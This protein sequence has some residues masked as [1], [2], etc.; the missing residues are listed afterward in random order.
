MQRCLGFTVTLN[1]MREK[2]RI[3]LITDGNEIAAWAYAMI[4]KINAIAGSEMVVLITVAPQYPKKQNLFKRFIKTYPTLL[5][6]LF[7]KLEAFLFKMTHN[8]FALRDINDIVTLPTLTASIDTDSNTLFVNA[9]DIEKLQLWNLDVLV[10]LSEHLP[11]KELLKLAKYGCWTLHHGDI[12][13]VKGGP[14]SFW[15]VIEHHP[16]TGVSLLMHTHQ[17]PY[18][19]LLHQSY[20]QT[21]GL[22]ITR[23]RNNCAWKALSFIPQKINELINGGHDAFLTRIAELNKHP[24]FYSGKVYNTPGNGK[25]LMLGTKYLWEYACQKVESLFYFEQWV[26]LY[27]IN[28]HEMLTPCLPR[29]KKM[30]PPKDKFWADPFVVYRNNKYYI[31]I[32]E[33]V[34]ATNKGHIAVIEMDENGNYSAPEI[35]LEKGYHLSYPFLLEDNGDLYMIPESFE[36]KTISL[37]KCIEFPHKWAFETHLIDNITAVD[38]TITIKDGKYWLFA[39]VVS[40]KG[41]ST[42]DEL[43]IF[44]A[45]KLV[46]NQW[47]PHAQNPVISDVK[48]ARPAGNFFMHNNQLY[49]PSQNCSNR[50][51]YGMQINH[52][53][54]LNESNYS[55]VVVDSINPF[56]HNRL[57]AT[58]TINHANKLTLIDALLKRRK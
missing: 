6:S 17:H 39:N 40:H 30:L 35:V 7:I 58:H 37:Y 26:L 51:G 41:A 38:A 10:G 31:F 2:L 33:L 15:E 4:K 43:C 21:D 36:N 11:H 8:A 19:T 53:I 18:P 3:G 42:H 49:R 47:T 29:Y 25:M 56:W 34:Y 9:A 1:Q 52:V 23:N 48:R 55:E 45:D 16:D 22:S 20:S 27:N 50:Y 54:E 32:E 14:P 5:Y 12:R 57:K 44:Y 28:N 24:L 13:N 46:T